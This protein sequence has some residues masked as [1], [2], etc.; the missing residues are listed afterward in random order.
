MKLVLKSK[1]EGFRGVMCGRSGAVHASHAGFSLVEIM[2]VIAMLGVIVLGLFSVFNQTQ[3]ALKSNNAQVD[4]MEAGRNAFDLI[5]REIEQAVAPGIEHTNIYEL[6]YFYPRI[7]YRNP[8]ANPPVTPEWFPMGL[9]DGTVRT[10]ILH[11]I[12]FLGRSNNWLTANG[13]FLG[14][15]TNVQVGKNVEARFTTNEVAQTGVGMLFYCSV[16]NPKNRQTSFLKNWQNYNDLRNYY[17]LS[18]NY[19]VADTTNFTHA[20]AYPLVDGVVHFRVLTYDGKMRRINDYF[21][22]VG[23]SQTWIPPFD[24]ALT[25]AIGTDIPAVLIYRDPPTTDSTLWYREVRPYFT[26]NN[27]PAYVEVELGLLSPQVLQKARAIPNLAAQRSFLTNQAH[28][29]LFF[30]KMIRLRNAQNEL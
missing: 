16:Q 29:V 26:S 7:Q 24:S 17:Q 12:F 2:V 11:E 25:N 28:A 9:N 14:S 27:L 23:P 4:V 6:A 13:F 10:N 15:I 18:R 20:A 1:V 8:S 30:R 5:T 3:R 22:H 19:L 21:N